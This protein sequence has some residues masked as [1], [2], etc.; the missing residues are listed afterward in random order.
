M[1][2]IAATIGINPI[3]LSQSLNGNPTIS[4]LQEVAM[5]L[6]VDVSELFERPVL[7]D[8][9]GSVYVKGEPH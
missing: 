8:A 7:N 3:T 2:Y 4:R 9:H 5:V 6:G 1:A